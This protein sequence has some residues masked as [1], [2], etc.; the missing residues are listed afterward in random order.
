M[1]YTRAA[2]ALSPGTP[3]PDGF[4]KDYFIILYSPGPYIQPFLPLFT[5]VALDLQG[6]H[7]KI[8]SCEHVKMCSARFDMTDLEKLNTRNLL[9][10]DPEQGASRMLPAVL[11]APAMLTCRRVPRFVYINLPFAVWSVTAR[12]TLQSTFGDGDDVFGDPSLNSLIV[13]G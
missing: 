7:D 6:L 12:S 8:P 3:R 10:N 9:P 11:R 1:T 5:P 13:C 4:D 2:Q